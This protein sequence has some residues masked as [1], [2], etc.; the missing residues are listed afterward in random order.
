MSNPV[1]YFVAL[2]L[3]GLLP[4]MHGCDTC[5]FD[6]SDDN[7]DDNNAEPASLTLKFSDAPLEE[8]TAV[9]IEVSAIEFRRSDAQDIVV[10]AFTL[11][12]GGVDY[13]DSPTFKI[14]L[15]DY[16]GIL[17]EDILTDFAI[18]ADFYN[19][20]FIAINDGTNDAGDTNMSFVEDIEG[21]MLPI[22]VDGEGLS[23]PGRQ[24]DADN[25]A[26]TIEF[27]LAR[28]LRFNANANT[29][30]LDAEGVRVVDDSL[31]PSLS[32]SVD[33]DLFDAVDE[34]EGLD[35]G[36]DTLWNR[37]Y[38]Y[39]GTVEAGNLADVFAGSPEGSEGRVAPFAASPLTLTGGGYE[40]FFGYLPPGDYTL[41]F[42]C[43]AER[44]DARDF[45]GVTVPL[46]DGQIISFT[47]NNEDN[48]T[49]Q[50]TLD[51]PPTC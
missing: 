39:E 23:L 50:F 42:S 36:D 12:T 7:D 5:G 46:P 41:A 4:L 10:D 19:E 28:A 30:T 34:C 29:Y 21:A 18:E 25:Q 35:E 14:D 16:P 33:T 27:G 1:K 51:D 24:I 44:D 37:V 3:L 26:I 13:Q 11:S 31:A 6:C 40:F 22:I 32:G 48:R 20:I 45:D 17:S 43:N 9:V 15:L 8:L 38:L 49:C 47:L 2:A